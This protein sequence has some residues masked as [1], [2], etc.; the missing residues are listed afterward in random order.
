MDFEFP[1]RPFHLRDL[2][3]CEVG[4][5]IGACCAVKLS[6]RDGSQKAKIGLRSKG[7]LPT[8]KSLRSS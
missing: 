3:T 7:K 4:L 2:L 1:F 8:R 6:L 5:Q